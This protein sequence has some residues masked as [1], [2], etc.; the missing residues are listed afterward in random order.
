MEN[1]S[2]TLILILLFSGLKATTVVA[3]PLNGNEIRRALSDIHSSVAQVAKQEDTLEKIEKSLAQ[4][5][6]DQLLYTDSINNEIKYTL[7]NVIF[8]NRYTDGM[9]T[10]AAKIYMLHYASGYDDAY[11]KELLTYHRPEQHG[12]TYSVRLGAIEGAA[13]RAIT[14]FTFMTYSMADEKT[15]L[16][17]RSNIIDDLVEIVIQ[18]QNEIDDSSDVERY[19]RYSIKVQA[20]VTLLSLIPLY[21]NGAK[22]PYR[23]DLT[24]AI[25]KMRGV[26][27]ISSN[28]IKKKRNFWNCEAA[29]LLTLYK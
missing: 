19:T 29:M 8:H 18:H 14:D 4:L 28:H 9:K 16:D 15:G 24:Q 23:S 21:D 3:A 26:K 5:S 6:K 11:A 22:D 27:E 1:K 20:D 2:F 12:W 10:T 17:G 25:A 13:L 7:R